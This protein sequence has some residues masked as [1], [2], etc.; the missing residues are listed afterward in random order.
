VPAL[1]AAGIDRLDL[2]MISHEDSDHAGGAPAVLR[3]LPAARLIGG[4]PS[5][6]P[7]FA[8]RPPQHC[9]AGDRWVWDG[10]RFSVLHPEAGDYRD[11]QRRRNRLSCVL[12]IET[13]G[14]A[15]LLT[16]D[17][18]GVDERRLVRTAPAELAADVLQVAHQGS[19]FSSTAEF[20]AAVGAREAIV[21]TGY[22]N[23]WGHP[24]REVVARLGAAGARLWRTD[25]DGALVVSLGAQ[26]GAIRVDGLRALRPRYWRSGDTIAA[27]WNREADR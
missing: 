12:K 25:R 16:A 17:L 14:A 22:R 7:L 24:H 15:M 2:L 6:H 5:E 9:V 8:G 13:A 18:E 27:P 19:R 26:P 21:A 4:L 11:P 23:R 1:R 3:E 20:L 10:V